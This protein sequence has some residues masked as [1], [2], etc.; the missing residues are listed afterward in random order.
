MKNKE[1]WKGTVAGALVV[2]CV[3][4]GAYAGAGLATKDTV[5]GDRKCRSKLTYLENLIDEYYLG[6][7]DE[8]KLQEGLYTGLLYGLD[9]P[10]SRYYTAEEYEAE[11]SSSQGTYVGIGILMEKNKEGGV[12]I[13]E[14]YEGGPGEEAGLK[15]GDII[16]AIDG[17]DITD[18][19]VSDVAD[20]VR[21]SDKDSVVLTVHR[22]NV[23]DA[24]EI[25]VPITDV[26]L[27]SVFH[28]MLDSKI[29]YIRITE[30]KGVTSEQYQ[31]E[32]DDLNSQGMEKLIVDLR[33]NPGGLLDSVCD[34]LRQILPEGLIVY[35]EDKDGNREVEKCDGKN[36]LLIPLAVLVN[37][38]S[39]SASEIFAGAVQDYG[40]GTI[41]GT[42]TYGKGVVQSIRQ[43]S[44]GSAIK[45]T[46][47]N[48]YTP[49]GNNIHK[50]GIKPD[51]EVSLD[52]SL[53]NKNKDEITHDEDNQL[54]EAIKAVEKEK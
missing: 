6:D 22:E 7:K 12:K 50:I 18:D 33:D 3:T 29:G 51:I 42:T 36:E 31:E 23:D 38:S 5:L 28:E 16:S 20:L 24:M 8:E 32:F 9:D 41:V 11:N 54:Q 34:I 14:C 2:A 48:Y 37:E 35:T 27:P 44:D 10:Y 19:E 15:A 26:E 40:I 49:K 21:N 45:L 47:A 52:T 25:T 43:L 17:E 4:V 46:I 30:F 13:V 39:A 53:L 1:F